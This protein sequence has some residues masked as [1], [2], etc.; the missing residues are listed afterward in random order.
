[1][2]SGIAASEVELRRC[3]ARRRAL[4]VPF[5][6]T[7]ARA[8]AP[9]ARRR[10]R[11]PPSLSKGLPPHTVVQYQVE[12]FQ[13]ETLLGGGRGVGREPSIGRGYVVETI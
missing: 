7:R 11:A 13:N 6:G 1:M 3:A 12:P 5:G 9:T 10:A 8:Q 4:V 2:V